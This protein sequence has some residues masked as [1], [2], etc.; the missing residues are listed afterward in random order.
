[1]EVKFEVNKREFTRALVQVKNIE[2][3]NKSIFILLRNKHVFVSASCDVEKPSVAI[4]REDFQIKV[5]SE[6]STS[7]S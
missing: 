1:M 5:K 4:F 7:L 3:E 2:S 6:N